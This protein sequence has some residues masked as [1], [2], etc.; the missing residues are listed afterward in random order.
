[1]EH[2]VERLRGLAR[3]CK[4]EGGVKSADLMY[5]AADEIE[6]LEENL[7]TVEGCFSSVE[8]AV[9]VTRNALDDNTK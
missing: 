9:R 4:D 5:E 8:A 1:M 6:R 7:R 3:F 2:L